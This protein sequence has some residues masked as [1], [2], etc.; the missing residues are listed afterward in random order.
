MTACEQGSIE[1]GYSTLADKIFNTLTVKS[2]VLHEMATH[3]KH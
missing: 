3:T 2:Y 1:T